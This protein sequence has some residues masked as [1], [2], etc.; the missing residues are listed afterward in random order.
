[1]NRVVLAE[2]LVTWEGGSPRAA[3]NRTKQRFYHEGVGSMV[4]ISHNAANGRGGEL[5]TVQRPGSVATE[6][7][8]WSEGG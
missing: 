3:M 7:D 2:R 5:S 8:R 6:L 4:T 1:M